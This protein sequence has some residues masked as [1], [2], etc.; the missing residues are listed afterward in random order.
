M[1]LVTRSCSTGLVAFFTYMGIERGRRIADLFQEVL[2]TGS[3][4]MYTLEL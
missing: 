4:Q 2:R 1:F 3:S